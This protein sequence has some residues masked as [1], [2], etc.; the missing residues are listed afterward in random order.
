MRHPDFP[1][2][3]V[4]STVTSAVTSSSVP[5]TWQANLRLRFSARAH[6]EGA[7]TAL[8][9]RR[10]KG[11]LLVQKPLYPEGDAICHAVVLHPPAGIAGGDQL[12][13]D[14]AVE[15]G[16]HA[17]LTTP[18]ATKWYKSLGR[19]ASQQVR[20]TVADGAHVDWL[21]QENIVF[22]DAR[23]RIATD[24]RVARGGSAIGWD[25]VVLGRQASGERWSQGALWLDTRVGELDGASKPLWI[26]QSYVDA[27]CALRTALPG[28]DGLPVLG[29]LWAIGE[30]ATAEL[31]EALA[32]RLPYR[33]DLRAG[34]TCMTS[35]DQRMLL[36]R[37]L[38]Q[39]IEP[40][41]HLL[42]DCWTQL[43]APIH[44]VP[45]RPLRLWAT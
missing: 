44:G 45:A 2:S 34:V 18:G 35:A 3:A 37:V 8:V 5:A 4:T 26:E 14:I 42:I 6:G 30:G 29:T 16:A 10:H 17:V 27:D 23:A 39:H 28:M 31:A 13:I 43:R 21:P 22:D 38:G 12:E 7:R 33:E 9:E 36:L 40:V 41:R 25:A 24:V 19:E 20:I 11:P 1:S 15:A 32:E